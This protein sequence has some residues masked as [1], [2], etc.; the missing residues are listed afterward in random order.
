MTPSRESSHSWV[1]SGSM[2]GSWLGM[3]LR[4]GPASSRAATVVG[5]FSRLRRGFSAAFAHLPPR[6]GEGHNQGGATGQYA[7]RA[8]DISA[9]QGQSCGMPP[10][11]ESTLGVHTPRVDFFLQPVVWDSRCRYAVG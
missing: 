7:E 4:M 1:S 2:S 10:P 3:P 6:G 5:P 9:G 11:R 8:S